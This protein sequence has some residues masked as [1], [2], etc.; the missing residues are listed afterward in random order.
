[1]IFMLDK[2]GYFM[3]P[4][5]GTKPA[6]RDQD[7][8]ALTSALLRSGCFDQSGEGMV[9][10]MCVRSSGRSGV[11]GGS[12]TSSPGAS[13]K[14]VLVG[15]YSLKGIAME[16]DNQPAIRERIRENQSL[17]LAMNHE[18][19]KGESIYVNAT[20]ENLRLNSVVLEPLAVRMK[21]NNLQLPSI[22]N[23]IASVDEFFQLAKLSR[24][25]DHCYQEAWSLR[26]L[27]GKLKRFTYR[28]CPPQA[29]LSFKRMFAVL[30]YPFQ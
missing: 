8:S 16:W 10:A 28:T 23:L 1:M 21:D 11:S 20:L 5:I 25:S 27:I 26:R 15:S 6:T 17:V 3:L 18:T 19:G 2:Y 29:W 22:D 30:R 13:P 7:A 12:R 24:G 14:N 4:C 9:V